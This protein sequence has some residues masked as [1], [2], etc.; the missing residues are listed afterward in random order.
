MARLNM[1][2]YVFMANMSLRVR[3]VRW[4]PG[5]SE[6]TGH[7]GAGQSVSLLWGMPEHEST[8][9]EDVARGRAQGT[10]R[11]LCHAVKVCTCRL[12][13]HP[14][15]QGKLCLAGP[16][17]PGRDN[18]AITISTTSM[19]NWSPPPAA[20]PAAMHSEFPHPLQHW[21][22]RRVE[23]QLFFFFAAPRV[24]W[25]LSSLTRDRTRVPCSGSVEF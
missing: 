23:F 10:E 6:H 20:T 12:S 4:P 5:V 2:G 21:W 19:R 7:V 9:T 22:V 16:P 17:P 18:R 25:D 15:V 24:M 1:L 13:I 11:L 8:P 3:R 14:Q